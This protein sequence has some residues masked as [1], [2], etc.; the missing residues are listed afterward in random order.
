M[1]LASCPVRYSCDLQ[2]D[3]ACSRGFSRDPGRVNGP[4]LAGELRPGGKDSAGGLAALVADRW[5]VDHLPRLLMSF[6][7]NAGIARPITGSGEMQWVIH[8]HSCC[9]GT[10]LIAAS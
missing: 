6:G 8:V 4:I 10:R 9:L 3:A 7:L 1:G 5:R 2:I